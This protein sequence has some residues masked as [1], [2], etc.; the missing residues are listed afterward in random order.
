MW[1]KSFR[2]KLSTSIVALEE[3]HLKMFPT[4]G[5]SRPMVFSVILTHKSGVGD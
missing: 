2:S 4:G 3:F 1:K 5:I